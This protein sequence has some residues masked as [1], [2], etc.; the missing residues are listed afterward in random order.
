MDRP[1]DRDVLSQ[2]RKV[3]EQYRLILEPESEVGYLVRA[4]EM[5]GVFADGPTP[6]AC[7]AAVRE[8]LVAAISVMIESGQTPPQPAAVDRRSAQVNIRLTPREK[9]LLEEQARQD[10]FRG[11]SDFVRAKLMSKIA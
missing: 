7:V 5:P 3:A 8:A 6:D 2:A 1:F 11:L 4:L 10:G 9:L